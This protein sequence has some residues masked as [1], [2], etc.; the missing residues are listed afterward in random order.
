MH[1]IRPATHREI[2]GKAG[3]LVRPL[4]GLLL[5]TPFTGLIG[6]DV[7]TARRS[8]RPELLRLVKRGTKTTAD[9]EQFALA[10]A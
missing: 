10:A 9:N 8:M 4:R 5:D 2:V 6:F 7:G 3:R 1:A